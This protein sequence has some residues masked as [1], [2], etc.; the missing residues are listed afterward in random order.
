MP[1]AASNLLVWNYPELGMMVTLE[2]RVL[3]EL[4]MLPRSMTRDPDPVPNPAALAGLSDVL[5]T[6]GGR[7]VFHLLPP[8]TTRLP[9][10]GVLARFRGG[11][12]PRLLVQFETPG[13]PADSLW[14]DWS[15]LDPAGAVRTRASRPLSPSACA[16]ATR[17]VGE[18]AAELE[19]GPHLVSVT[20]R[21]GANGRGI[22]R[23]RIELPPPRAALALS[24]VVIACGRP[25][26][27]GSVVRIEPN[28]GARVAGAG[29]LTAYFE[30]YHLRPGADGLG[31]FRYVYSVRSTAPDSRHWVQKLLAPPP[32]AAISV[33]SDEWHLGDLRRQFISV[34]VAG[35]PAGRYW[36]EITVRDLVAEEEVTGRLGF[37]KTS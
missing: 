11:G 25:E 15:V 13:G 31:R 20:V 17:R 16:A 33:S 18:F 21:D 5:G 14:A 4:Y 2:D 28:P 35:L 37:T 23:R 10:E 7:G 8:G 34:P 32:P 24:D 3:S 9:L 1:A 22:L 12:G 30:I 36:L 6:P 29:P 26:V 19:P 27:G